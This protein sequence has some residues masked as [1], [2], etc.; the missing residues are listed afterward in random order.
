MGKFEKN[1]FKFIHWII[2]S[3][4]H[5]ILKVTAKFVYIYIYIYICILFSSP[6][7]FFNQYIKDEINN[8]KDLSATRVKDKN[9]KGQKNSHDITRSKKLTFQVRVS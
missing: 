1:L 6:L 3:F 8:R 4:F 7:P 9:V 5:I 2:I